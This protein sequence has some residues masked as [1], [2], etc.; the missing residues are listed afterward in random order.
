MKLSELKE[1]IEK[2]ISEFG[3]VD[4]VITPYYS[5]SGFPIGYYNIKNSYGHYESFA[6]D[7]VR[8]RIQLQNVNRI[9]KVKSNR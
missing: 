6:R 1:M 5:N 3:D 8:L 9:G 2:C 7:Q 4:V